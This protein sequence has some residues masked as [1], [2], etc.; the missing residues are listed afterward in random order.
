MRSASRIVM[1]L[2]LATVAANT[3]AG[4]HWGGMRLTSVRDNQMVS[5]NGLMFTTGTLPASTPRNPIFRD[6]RVTV[7]AGNR[8]SRGVLVPQTS[9]WTNVSRFFGT[10]TVRLNGH[11]VSRNQ[12]GRGFVFACS[13]NIGTS[14]QTGAAFV[15][16]LTF[17]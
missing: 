3:Q 16:G 7:Y 8:D 6:R 11:Q 2:M 5:A 14:T 4:W 17:R 10:W 9:N 13:E 12:W 15:D 1:V